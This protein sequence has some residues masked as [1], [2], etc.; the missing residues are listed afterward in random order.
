M[1][2]AFVDCTILI[3]AH[4]RDAGMK[5]QRAVAKLSELW[6]SGNGRLSIQVLEEFYVNATQ[7][8]AIP[9][10]RSTV[11]DVIKTYGAWIHHATP[12]ETIARAVESSELA[13]SSFWVCAHGG[14][15]RGS[16]CR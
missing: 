15:G 6:E 4:D 7:K 1:S 10:A 14:L 3:Y 2:V 16:R 11:R 9:V 8:L 12:V 13:R 5:R